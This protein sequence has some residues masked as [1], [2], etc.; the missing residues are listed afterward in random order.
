L[1]KRFNYSLLIASDSNY[2]NLEPLTFYKRFFYRLV[3][4]FIYKNFQKRVSFF[5]PISEEAKEVLTD[6]FGIQPSRIKIGPYCADPDFFHFKQEGRERVRKGFNIKPG[7]IVICY[8][9]KIYPLKDL[10]TLILAASPVLRARED[11]NLLIVGSGPRG[12]IRSLKALCGDLIGRNKIIF[13]GFIRK[14]EL[15]DFFSAC[16]VGVWPRQ[17][18]QVIPEAMAASLPVI[19]CDDRGSS[20]LCEGGIGF[21]FPKGDVK[22]LSRILERMAADKEILRGLR[23]PTRERI[24][25]KYTWRKRAQECIEIYNEAIRQRQGGAG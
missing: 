10:R 7:N 2:F 24:I 13:H 3:R 19:V 4:V 18:S 12:H 11:V 22:A 21:T 8:V 1:Q 23:G 16:D 25:S 9:G 6:V 5:L 14:E 20:Y 17:F 15:P